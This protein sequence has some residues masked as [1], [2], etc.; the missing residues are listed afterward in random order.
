MNSRLRQS[1]I[2]LD[3]NL[4]PMLTNNGKRYKRKHSHATMLQTPTRHQ[5]MPKTPETIAPSH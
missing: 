1:N 4:P 2:P 3:R 5:R